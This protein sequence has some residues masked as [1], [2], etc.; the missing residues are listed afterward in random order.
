MLQQ[1]QVATVIPYFERWMQRFPTIHDLAQAE[2]SDVL[3][4]WQGLGYYRRARNLIPG[5]KFIE[6]HGIPNSVS[7]WIK[8]PGVG[9]YTAGAIAS[10]AQAQPAPLVDGNVARVFARLSASPLSGNALTRSAWNWAEESVCEE[11]PG[12]WNQALMELGATVCRPRE[13]LCKICPLEKECLGYRNGIAHQLPIRP[14]QKPVTSLEQSIW[15]AECNGMYATLR[16]P[17]GEWWAGMRSFP[18]T[19]GHERDAC[20][21]PGASPIRVGSIRHSVTRFRINL[22]VFHTHVPNRW[23]NYDWRSAD[24]L[25]MDALPAP[26]R[27]AWR[28]TQSKHQPAL[29]L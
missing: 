19:E 4:I 21:F 15:I 28:L 5:A 2:E 17:S 7:D 29:S 27:R 10:I 25:Q 6:N 1:T 14:Q 11:A 23:K 22:A 18:R 13:P 20:P 24:E 26:H 9:R 16:I 3:Q 8:V 12:D